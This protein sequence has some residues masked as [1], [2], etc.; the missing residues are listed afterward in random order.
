M[1]VYNWNDIDEI[2]DNM[3]DVI[4]NSSKLATFALYDDDNNVLYVEILR[5]DFNYEECIKR[6]ERNGVD[7]SKI[8]LERIA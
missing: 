4:V 7:L 6:A 3:V 1:T 2:L 8:K 5:P